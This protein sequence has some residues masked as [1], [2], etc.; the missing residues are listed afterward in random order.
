M[1]YL[2]SRRTALT[3]F[4]SAALLAGC[5]GRGQMQSRS[6]TAKGLAAVDRL[7]NDAVAS[8]YLPGAVAL[9][10]RGADTHV[11]V[12]GAKGSASTNG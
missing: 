4:G 11:C 2:P 5:Q 12:A 8:Q 6:F 9:L 7:L 3:G 1:G 10:S